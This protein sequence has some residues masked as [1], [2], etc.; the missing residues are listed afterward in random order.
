MLASSG[1][2]TGNSV[3]F[4]EAQPMVRDISVVDYRLARAIPSDR[5]RLKAI[6]EVS[7]GEYKAPVW[8]VSVGSTGESEYKVLLTAGVHG[9]EP[10][11]VEV[12]LRTIEEIAKNPKHYEHVSFDI[13]PVVNPWGW[14][15]DIRFNREGIDINRDF[16]SFVSQEA[17]II[18]QF[19]NNKKYD[20]VI[21]HHEDPRAEGFYMFQNADSDTELSSKVIAGL[22]DMG[23]PI[24]QNV[25]MIILKTKDGLID[26]PMW[27]LRYMQLTRQLSV[28]SY[29]RLDGSR[30]AFTVETPTRLN[31]DQRV[32]IHKEVLE[33]LLQ[34]LAGN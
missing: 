11:G 12:L 23:Y 17:R 6:G 8:A 22:R 20:L 32:R 13:I 9:N 10:A 1:C 33:I 4:A 34:S 7:Y 25:S 16:A 2:A 24:E 15:H 19:T 31:W 5:L 29:F 21:D 27:G 14:S 28:P 30:K 3:P 26:A 18:R